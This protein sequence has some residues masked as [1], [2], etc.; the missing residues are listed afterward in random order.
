M[1]EKLLDKIIAVAYGDAGLFDK[2]IIYRKAKKNSCVKQ[3]LNEHKLTANSV[4]N[5]KDIEL[6]ESTIYSVQDKMKYKS[7][8]D[9]FGSVIYSGFLRKPILSA[10]AI[11]IV[12][13]IVSILIFYQPQPEP[14][15]TKAEIEFAQKQL[16]ESISI[17]NKVFSKAE[18]Q[19]DSEVL[20]NH[21]SKQLNKGF[22]LINDLLI[23]G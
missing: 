14:T 3:L 16:E 12:V 8:N 20:S 9:F 15:F 19:F 2:F 6:P 4:H 17:V 7:K 11:G 18:H 23:G 21:V 5:L 1:D 22:Y 10:G 13:L